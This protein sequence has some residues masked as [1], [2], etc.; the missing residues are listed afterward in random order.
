[1]TEV[2]RAKEYLLD[3][4]TEDQ[5]ENDLTEIASKVMFDLHTREV[6]A[7]FI[8]EIK[9]YMEIQQFDGKVESW[10]IED[11][12]TDEIVVLFVVY[13]KELKFRINIR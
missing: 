3:T 2:A 12:K 7:R 5:I 13:G 1:M 4:L 8:G 10:Y 6:F 9:A 11:Y